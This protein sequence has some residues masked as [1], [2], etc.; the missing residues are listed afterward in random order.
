MTS[1][2]KGSGTIHT[3]NI[4]LLVGLIVVLGVAKCGIEIVIQILP[5]GRLIRVI[6]VVQYLLEIALYRPESYSKFVK[7]KSKNY[8]D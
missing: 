3:V 7:E 2:D 5:I 1:L 4:F 8:G 6:C